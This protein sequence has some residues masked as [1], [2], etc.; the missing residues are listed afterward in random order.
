MPSVPHNHNLPKNHAILSSA[1]EMAE[2]RLNR[3]EDEDRR[4]HL[5]Q[6]QIANDVSLIGLGI[7]EKIAG[8]LV[9]EARADL[10]NRVVAEKVNSDLY[11]AVAGNEFYEFEGGEDSENYLGSLNFQRINAGILGGAGLDARK[12][13]RA[14]PSMLGGNNYVQAWVEERFGANPDLE[15]RRRFVLNRLR[16]ELNLLAL[17]N[18]LAFNGLSMRYGIAPLAT[19]PAVDQCL[20]DLTEQ[21]MVAD[22]G[23]L[24]ITRNESR[25]GVAGI[26]GFPGGLDIADSPVFADLMML[27]NRQ[28]RRMTEAGLDRIYNTE[29]LRLFCDELQRSPA[30]SFQRQLIDRVNETL[31]E[32]SLFPLDRNFDGKALIAEIRARYMEEIRR[33][34]AL[35]TPTPEENAAETIL[36]ELQTIRR[37][38]LPAESWNFD[39]AATRTGLESVL[40]TLESAYDGIRG[41]NAE[42]ISHQNIIGDASAVPPTGLQ[43]RLIDL[44]NQ[45]AGMPA[46]DRHLQDLLNR[47]SLLNAGKAPNVAQNVGL[48]TR[49]NE[50]ERENQNIN[51]YQNE[52]L[53]LNQ[54][55]IRL[56]NELN[57]IDRR[58]RHAV[59]NNRIAQ[60]NNTARINFLN[61]RINDSRRII[62]GVNLAQI[63]QEIADNTARIAAIDSEIAVVNAQ[64]A[65]MGATNRANVQAQIDATNAEILRRNN[66]INNL[67]DRI[68]QAESGIARA[69]EAYFRAL[70]SARGALENGLGNNLPANWAFRDLATI[71]HGADLDLHIQTLRN[72]ITTWFDTEIPAYMQENEPRQRIAPITLLQR[73]LRRQY[74]RDRGLEANIFSE[75]ANNYAGTKAALRSIAARNSDMNRSTN[76]KAAEFVQR[77]LLRR[78]LDRLAGG[79]QTVQDVVGLEPITFKE[80]SADSLIE[81]IIASNPDFAA[82]KGIN[83]FSTI[84]DVRNYLNKSGLEISSPVVVRFYETIREAINEYKKVNKNLDTRIKSGD[85]DIEGLIVA[86]E[87]FEEE[88]WFADQLN[89]LERQKTPGNREQIWVSM[90]DGARRQRQQ[91]IDGILTDVKSPNAIWRKL[92]MKNE[93][94]KLLDK[95]ILEASSKLAGEGIGYRKKNMD[96]LTAE[97]D[98]APEG[99]ALRA[100]LE[101]EIVALNNSIQTAEKEIAES[102]DLYERVEAAKKYIEENNLGRKD[103][104]AY[105]EQVGL[106]QVFEKMGTNFAFQRFWKKTKTL[107]SKGWEK[108][109]DA[110]KWSRENFLHMGTAKKAFS[111][112]RIAATPVTWT[113]GLA[114]KTAY[115]PFRMIGRGLSYSTHIPRRLLGTMSKSQMRIYLRNRIEESQEKMAALESKQA[116]LRSKLADVPYSWDRKRILRKVNRLETEKVEL[117]ESLA[118]FQKMAGDRSIDLGKIDFYQEGSSESEE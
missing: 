36:R 88:K 103:K 115:F 49:R 25:D 30:A 85:W 111:L 60:Q 43:A 82:F 32:N 61:D 42:I 108:T 44:Q 101:A 73:F 24:R 84:R 55:N 100:R 69:E 105:L 72:D 56:A 80:L 71:R 8:Q 17:T 112:G 83:K 29:D 2:R 3:I 75:E 54:A 50:I 109:K 92:L 58:D 96:R 66:E 16:P 79:V 78:G 53:A 21:L 114:V 35:G 45:L 117:R 46:I 5:E 86:M 70:R 93:L 110:Y 4:F 81:Q 63:D 37:D 116:K 57:L 11:R 15:A 34:A 106:T 7:S 47:V 18:P 31:I 102:K 77:G 33:E 64:I 76:N 51:N 41:P 99:S 95:D 14:I 48:Q 68:T 20:D 10:A 94:K 39:P 26:A 12:M 1:D 22:L 40:Q 87:K 89:E 52:I 19:Y 91:M 74:L 113:L 27:A 104:K 97:R 90:M 28:M 9:G 65:A 62:N 107:A 13:A 118:E 98:A 6:M 23:Q 38:E 67:R 59:T